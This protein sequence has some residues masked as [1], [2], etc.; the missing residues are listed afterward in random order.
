M[1]LTI[2]KDLR[3][4]LKFSIASLHGEKIFAELANRIVDIEPI[5]FFPVPEKL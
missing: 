4:I 2:P 3:I 5:N 1:L